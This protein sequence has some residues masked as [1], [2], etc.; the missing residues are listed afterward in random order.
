MNIRTSGRA[1]LVIAA[2]LLV[3]A[4]GALHATESDTPSQASEPAATVGSATDTSTEPAKATKHHVAKKSAAKSRKSDRLTSKG[5]KKAAEEEST[6]AE[7]ATPEKGDMPAS[8][9]NANAHWPSEA[10]ATNTYNMTSQAG[11]VLSQIGGQ[12]EQPAT[13]SPDAG[14]GNLQVVAAD[15]LNDLDRAITDDKPAL[16]LA[17]ATI[18]TPAPEVTVSQDSTTWDKTSL[19]GKI[20]IAFGGLLTM[21]SA[22]RM[23][24][25]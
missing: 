3:C 8:V 7:D 20:F 15:Q 21:A 19:V 25:A 5:A 6:K 18:D 16:T 22:A 23:F 11:G 13:A 10:P 9:A 1:A 17:K 4:S 24:I 14:P 2:G 12:P